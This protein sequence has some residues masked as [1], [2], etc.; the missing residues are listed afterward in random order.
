MTSN[1]TTD[2]IIKINR[3]VNNEKETFGRVHPLA[4]DRIPLC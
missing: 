2:I 1:N 3:L 4:Q